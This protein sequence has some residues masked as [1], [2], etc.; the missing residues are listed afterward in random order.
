MWLKT[1][2]DIPKTYQKSIQQKTNKHKEDKMAWGS[3]EHN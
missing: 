2:T 1:V 3:D